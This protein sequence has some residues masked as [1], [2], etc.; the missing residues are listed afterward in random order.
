MNK[1]KIWKLKF[2]WMFTFRCSDTM[3]LVCVEKCDSGWFQVAPTTAVHL[4][5]P[6][7]VFAHRSP[8]SEELGGGW[9]ASRFHCASTTGRPQF[10]SI[11]CLSSADI[12]FLHFQAVSFHPISAPAAHFNLS[13]M[14]KLK[15]NLRRHTLISTCP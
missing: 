7:A 5:V 2:H 1:I 13:R 6:S 15:L 11:V 14:L 12:H 3:S 8:G 10:L 9:P 4:S